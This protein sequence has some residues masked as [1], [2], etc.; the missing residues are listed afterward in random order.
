MNDLTG[1]GSLQHP[2][3]G[4]GQS[5]SSG[6]GYRRAPQRVAQAPKKKKPTQNKEPR[7][8][9]PEWKKVADGPHQQTSRIHF[10]FYL[11]Y[12]ATNYSFYMLLQNLHGDQD[13]MNWP[14]KSPFL[15]RQVDLVGH[16]KS[17][18]AW[19]DLGNAL[20]EPGA[21]VIYWGHS[22]RAK[23]SKKARKLRPVHDSA[24]ASRDIGINQLAKIVKTMNAKCFILA[25]CATRG[26]IT[27]KDRDTALI[28]TDS[29][30]N[31]LT[32]SRNWAN[33]LRQF[34]LKFIGGGTITECLGEA[35]TYFAG[36]SEPEDKFVLASG[37]G[38]MTLSS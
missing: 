5:Q 20:H 31:L 30:K 8:P 3:S 14:T 10:L 25:S 32:D 29:G 17:D 7:T 33:A 15:T 22:E 26:C 12:I 38:D 27:S 24:N 2:G 19:T 13:P 37:K 16:T 6:S 36:S 9:R 21:I 1:Y 23:N 4:Y 34:L 35:N 28:V 18:T 11:P